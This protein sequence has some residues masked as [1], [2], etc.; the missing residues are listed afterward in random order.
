MAEPLKNVQQEIDHLYKQHFGKMVASLLRFS[1]DIDLET[2]EDLV[3]DAFAAALS[4]WEKQLPDNPAGWIFTVCR[5]KALNKLKADKKFL[6]LHQ[7]PE[8]APELVSPAITFSAEF[9]DDE[10]LR[11]LFACAH[12]DLAPK[13]QVVI[14]LK[15]V[16]NFK[17]ATIASLL[18]MTIDGIDKLLLRARQKIREEKL[19]LIPPAPE[20]MQQRLPIVHKI[21]Y[22]IFNEGHTSAEGKELLRED[23]CEEALIL[24]KAIL[25][26]QMGNIDTLALYALMLLNAARFKARFDENGE[27][28]DLE[29]QDRSLWNQDLIKLGD[30][31]FHQ[32]KGSLLSSYHIEAYIAWLHSTATSFATTEWQTI[33][34]L[35]KQLLPNPFVELNYAIALYYAGEVNNAFTLLNNLQRS[36]FMNSYYLLNATLGKLYMQEN[37]HAQAAVYFSKTLSQTRSSAEAN[38]IRKMLSKLNL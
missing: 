3:Q 12:P 25:D 37:N 35:Y 2:A 9:P 38:Y 5:N 11:L 7:A 23:L 16:I 17:V 24:N 30:Y 6:R 8:P 22:L 1:K 13:V 26:S 14:T 36:P 33:A 27:L 15:Y 10:Q 19:L 29:Q 18:G 21:I 28:L 34:Q 4:L 32:S 20:A 31:Y